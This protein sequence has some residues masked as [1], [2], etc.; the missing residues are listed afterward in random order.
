MRERYV[1]AMSRASR[2]PPIRALKPV[3]AQSRGSNEPLPRPRVD[4]R[5]SSSL[6]TVALVVALPVIVLLGAGWAA[7]WIAGVWDVDVDPWWVRDKILEAANEAAWFVPLVLAAVLALEVRSASLLQPN[8]GQDLEEMEGRTYVLAALVALLGGGPMVLLALAR[9]TVGDFA[10]SALIAVAAVLVLALLAEIL[11]RQRVRDADVAGLLGSL[12][13]RRQVLSG[14]LRAQVRPQI[15]PK[16]MRAFLVFFFKACGG[17]VLLASLAFASTSLRLEPLMLAAV[18]VGLWVPLAGIGFLVGRSANDLTGRL[19][20]WG[21]VGALTLIFGASAVES[22]IGQSSPALT[23]ALMAALGSA[24]TFAPRIGLLSAANQFARVLH[25]R[26]VE[27][28]SHRI[29]ALEAYIA[30]NPALRRVSVN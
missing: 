18:Y 28:L 12:Q 2:Q 10:A 30:S 6:G 14:Q 7:P 25:V 26:E 8:L 1:V 4:A 19:V 17:A 15:R 27:R 20:G 16:P 23:L 22:P 29:S 3:R 13:E 21:W 24:A 11:Y 5:F 9:L